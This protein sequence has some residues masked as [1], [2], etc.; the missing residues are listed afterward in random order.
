[1]NDRT[2]SFEPAL[3]ALLVILAVFAGAAPACVEPPAQPELDDPLPGLGEDEL[4]RFEAGELVFEGTF[5]PEQGL[6]PLFN[7]DSCAFCHA[8]PVDGGNGDVRELHVSG[9][10][11]DGTCDAL[12]DLGGPVIQS[13]ATQ[14]LTDALGISAEPVPAEA[15]ASG[16]RTTPDV[17]GFGLLDAIPDATILAL[18]DPDDRDG[19]GVSGRVHRLP[20]G[21]VGRFGRKAAVSSLRE[22]NDGAF[23]FELGLTTPAHPLENTI[24]GAP[25]PPGVDPRLEPE[26]AAEN[27]ALTDDYVRFLAPPAPGP[28]GPAERRG[29][30]LFVEIGCAGCHVPSLRTGPHVVAALAN[31]TVHA[32]TDLLLHDLGPE[33]ADLCLGAAEPAEFRTEP[34]MGLRHVR[35]FL[36]DGRAASVGEAIELHGGEASRARA[37]YRALSPLERDH[38]LAFLASL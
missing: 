15:L 25:L 36:H 28:R 14:A 32:Y 10:G 22:F 2:R 9:R 20:D 17:F 37:A 34:L 24:A 6:G 13:R 7:A 3:A 31:K 21:R 27:V 4:E 8:D 35:A 38:L 1:M 16:M 18:A 19:D 33:L 12:E 5:T 23:L 30:A 29:E 11:A 26:V